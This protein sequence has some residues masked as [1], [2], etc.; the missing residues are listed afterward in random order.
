MITSTE[1]IQVTC[2]QCKRSLT[3]PADSVGKQGR[4]PSCSSLFPVQASVEAQFDKL[5]RAVA[6]IDPYR[7]PTAGN[8]PAQPLPAQPS[9]PTTPLASP[10]PP[11]PRATATTGSGKYSHG[12]GW[13]HRGW[14]AGVL[15]GLTMMGIAVLWFVLGLACGIV[16]YYPPILFVVGLIGLVRGVLTG[17]VRGR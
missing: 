9:A 10:Y 3:V 5:S 13:E 14:D 17:N 6:S 2:P 1:K 15:G 8:D 11:A 16:F 4:C 12:F 7:A